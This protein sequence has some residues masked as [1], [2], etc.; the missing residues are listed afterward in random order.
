MISGNNNLYTNH[1]I[2]TMSLNNDNNKNMNDKR[3]NNISIMKVMIR[4][5]N[6]S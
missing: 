3:N 4:V 1:T 2:S 6:R 5:T